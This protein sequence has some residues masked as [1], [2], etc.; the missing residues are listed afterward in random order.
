MIWRKSKLLHPSGINLETPLL[1][2]SFSSKGFLIGNKGKSDVCNAMN[3]TKEILEESLLISAYDIY[4]KH[5]PDPK[6]FVCTALTFID[7]GGYETSRSYDFSEI[8]K[9]NLIHKSWDL[10]KYED[11][12]SSWPNRFPGVI[13]SFDHGNVRK[14]FV[15]QIKDAKILF[16]KYDNFL[17]DFIIKPETKTQNY[18]K[19]DILIDNLI[20]LKD[21]NIIGLTEKELGKSILERMQFICLLRKK[22]DELKFK[23]PIHIFGSLD[24]ITSI[25]YFLAGAEIFDGLTWLKYSYFNGLAIYLNNYGTINDKVGIHT[26]DKKVRIQSIYDNLNYLSSIKYVI[27]EFIST[28]DFKKFDL[29]YNGMSKIIERNYDTFINTVKDQL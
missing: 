28:N 13:I 19:F 1:I 8:K 26:N 4:Y 10:I 29:L 3:F 6:D 25:L 18:I 24:P 27:Y 5:I 23:A 15:K 16:K 11:V 2:P 7:S 22:M 20:Q 9:E 17:N 12:L 14:D 21:F